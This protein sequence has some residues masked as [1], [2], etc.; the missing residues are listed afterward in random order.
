M[1]RTLA[2]RGAALAALGL[3]A[4]L[5]LALPGCGSSAVQGAAESPTAM[6]SGGALTGASTDLQTC[7]TCAGG[8]APQ[9]FGKAKT[10]NGVQVVDIS[11]KGGFYSPNDITV[12]A[13]KPVTVVFTGRAKGCLSK[14]MFTSL[15]MKADFTSGKAT[16]N[17]GTLK[18]GTYQFTC[19][20]K[21][22]GGKIVAQ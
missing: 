13:G 20:M 15:N 12:T 17:L 14:P 5:S 3:M 9:V 1:T 6:M 8:T 18:A 22:P 2:R 21:M 16:L 10:V 19:G 11:V 4:A 7:A